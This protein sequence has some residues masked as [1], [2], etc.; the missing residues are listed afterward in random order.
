VF[1]NNSK[2]PIK[3]TRAAI[4]KDETPEVEETGHQQEFLKEL[5]I[6]NRKL[7]KTK[8]EI[9]EFVSASK[10][11]KGQAFANSP[12]KTCYND[13]LPAS[14]SPIN[15]ITRNAVMNKTNFNSEYEEST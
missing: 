6:D 13:K 14:C 5:C 4:K 15:N 10:T 9:N 12:S 2:G 11:D 7:R 3:A 8:G 1:V